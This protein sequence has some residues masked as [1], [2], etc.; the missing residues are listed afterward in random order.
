[1]AHDEL[2]EWARV[3]RARWD[4]LVDVHLASEMYDLV[5]LRSGGG[6]LVAIDEV[7]LPR[8]APEGWQGLRVLHLQCHFGADS[9]VFAQRGADVVGLDF[10]MPAVKQARALADELGLGERAR[11][12]CANLYDARHALPEPESFDVVYTSWGTIGWL[13]D[14]VE[15]ARIIAWF[16][17]PGG[18]LYFADGH[19]A[20]FVF[21]EP[22]PNAPAALLDDGPAL[23]PPARYGYFD[24]TPL[25]IDEDGDYADPDA[26]V[27]NSRT[28]EFMH[29]LG[30]T[31][32][33]LIDAGL[34]IDFLHEH[35]AVPWQMFSVLERRGDGL[36]AWPRTAWLPLGMSLAATRR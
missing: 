10:S 1:M 12:V 29:P 4:E 20:A 34:S 9:L 28:I 14:I 24:E 22:L 8:V 27:A 5:D 32:T 33:A 36:W 30:S 18:R 16:L 26:R 25:D 23:F 11:F 3:N 13:P 6:K 35:D 17:K 15:W 31:V 21:D 19:P 7:E 2:P